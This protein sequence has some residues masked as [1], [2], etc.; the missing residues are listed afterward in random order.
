MCNN[1]R[2]RS[3]LC[4]SQPDRQPTNLRTAIVEQQPDRTAKV[5][6]HLATFPDDPESHFMAAELAAGDYDQPL[7][8]EHLSKL[9][10]DG[11]HW[12]LQRELGIAKRC[13]VQGRML[14]EEELLRN[15][16]QLDPTHGD[17]NHRL[18][19][20]LQVQGR[21]WESAEPFMMQLRRGKC[22]GDELM[23]VAASERFFREDEDFERK[24][25]EFFAR[26]IAVFALCAIVA[27]YVARFVHRR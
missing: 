15:V 16:L 24:A 26:H 18:G 11:G 4:G 8:I 5:I 12:Q 21:S 20:L 1:A 14:D 27:Y 3:S 13:R 7:A 17:A 6:E 19:H 10:Q 22:R 23:G 9:P 2:T 25:L